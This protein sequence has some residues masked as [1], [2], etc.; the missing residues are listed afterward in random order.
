MLDDE[1]LVKL[2]VR[3]D[4]L[5]E[6][7][8]DATPEEV[9]EDCPGFVEEYKTR[10]ASLK[11][12]D[13]LFETDDGEDDDS[14][15]RSSSATASSV[16]TELP[17][18]SL[19][20]EQFL[21]TI[22]DSG[23]MNAEELEAFQKSVSADVSTD[24]QSLARELVQ[25]KQLTLYQASVLLAERSDPLLLDR[26]IIL[27]AIDSG[28]MGLVFKALHRSLDR[29]VALKTLPPAAVNSEE[30]VALGSRP[31]WTPT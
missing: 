7:G 29:V 15:T 28:G 1:K 13:W 3:R 16:E 8:R 30:K 14:V 6:Q 4:D 5:L 18:S 25:R 24:T 20:I 12:T 27:D 19:T 11:R 22:T 17:P 21:R 23:L 26:Y 10:L 9:C 31:F 2:L